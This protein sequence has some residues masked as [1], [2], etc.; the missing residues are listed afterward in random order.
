MEAD[1]KTDKQLSPKN[2]DPVSFFEKDSGFVFV[3]K[4]T[5]KLAS[6]IYIV[7]NL[8]SEN[9]PMKW[10]L[11]KKAGDL[12]SFTLNYKDISNSN[13]SEFAYDMRTHVLELV[14][15]LE[16]SSSAGLVSNMNFSILKQEFSNLTDTFN[17]SK[18]S[19]HGQ[20]PRALFDIAQ[21]QEKESNNQKNYYT[22]PLN[23]LP[24]TLYSEPKDRN[25]HVN[26]SILK[27]SNRQNIILSLL[28]KNKELIIKDFTEVIK[29]C[30]E[31]TI[32]RELI[33]L[34]SEGTVKRTGQRRWSR[35]SLV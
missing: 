23:A 17:L 8:F 11:R 32:Q 13:H 35:Y 20:L 26:K 19:L 27:R 30:S 12:V 18:E 2:V 5:E 6:A 28:K 33:S 24:R 31:K 25:I 10:T 3:Y 7:T 4:K 15:L 29:D 34:I 1:K 21:E 16:I 22:E 9:E 14:S